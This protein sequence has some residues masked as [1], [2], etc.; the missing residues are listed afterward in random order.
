[1]IAATFVVYVLIMLAAGIIACYKT[2]N[3]SDYI[4]GGRRLNS[5]V[6]ALSAQ[7]SD[8][9]GWLLLGLPGY[10]YAAGCEAVWLATGLLIGTY[11]NWRFVAALLRDYTFKAGDSLTISEYLECRF[12]DQSHILRLISGVFI[13]VFFMFY[14]SSGLVAGGKLFE[15]V[16]GMP[17]RQAVLLGAST[18]IVYTFLGG[19]IAVCWTD[20][21]QGLLML[22]ALTALPCFILQDQGGWTSAASALR[23][24]N[25][26]FLNMFTSVDGRR[27][28]AVSIIS[29]LGWG[30]GYFGQPHILTRFM[31]I[32]SS[33]EIPMARH[34]AMGWVSICLAGSVLIGLGGIVALRDHLSGAETEMVFIMLVKA[35]L[36]P[37]PAGICLAAI[38]AAIMST[39]DS[40]LLVSSSVLA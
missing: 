10:A 1:M 6:T 30:L 27:L 9:S 37:V 33:S 14:T 11:L 29:L 18:I 21:I 26:E 12:Q 36:H 17:Y 13:L 34:L 20:C 31:A 5:F 7:A 39:A 28:S 32:R 35:L 24:V 40:Q 25:P 8:M 38:L 22:A 3:L 2:T 19:F 4:L 15:S 16:F 23:E